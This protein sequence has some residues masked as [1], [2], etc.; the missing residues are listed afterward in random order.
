MT[1]GCAPCGRPANEHPIA[2]SRLRQ[3]THV[4]TR[5]VYIHGGVGE[6][7]VV[8][9]LHH[10]MGTARL[11]VKAIPKGCINIYSRRE[12]IKDEAVKEIKVKKH[13]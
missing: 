13:A 6:G 11:D 3:S 1:F 4:N 8:L 10:V 2:T 5:L 12:R 7:C 9:L